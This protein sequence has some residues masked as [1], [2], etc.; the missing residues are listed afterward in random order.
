M[1]SHNAGTRRTWFAPGVGIVQL[2]A[3]NNFGDEAVIQLTGYEITEQSSDYLPLAIGNSWTY[4]WANIPEEYT[5]KDVYRVAANKGDLWYLEN[6]GY[7][8]KKQ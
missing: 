5:A 8:Y 3:H 7:A 4:G 6:Y 2:I 1:R